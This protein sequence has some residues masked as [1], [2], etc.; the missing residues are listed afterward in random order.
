M[1]IYVEGVDSNAHPFNE[2][3]QSSNV[4]IE[5]LAFFTAQNLTRGQIVT[6]SS[7]GKFRIQAKIIWVGDLQKTGKREVGASLI[8]PIENW[9]LK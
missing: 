2:E 3:T 5:G 8:P 7:P 4:S 6:V 1:L 9:V